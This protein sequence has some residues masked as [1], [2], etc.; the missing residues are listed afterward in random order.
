[1]VVSGQSENVEVPLASTTSDDHYNGNL[2]F[3]VHEDYEE[4]QDN[5]LEQSDDVVSSSTVIDSGPYLNA[6]LHDHDVESQ[7]PY[8][9]VRPRDLP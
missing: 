1:M 2:V 4:D 9:F 5:D 8:S 6:E 7:S 3:D